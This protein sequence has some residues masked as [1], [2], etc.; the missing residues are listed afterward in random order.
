PKFEFIKA[1]SLGKIKGVDT[2][3]QGL[4]KLVVKYP[5]AEV[6]PLANDVLAAIKKQRT[7][8][9]SQQANENKTPVDTFVVSLENEHFLL[10]I[11]PNNPKISDAYK[12]NLIEFNEV[13][14]SDKKFDLK[15]NLLGTDK[16]MIVLK[17]FANGKAAME[18]YEN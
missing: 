13:F 17:S 14:Y 5:N 15:S 18:Y 12:S 10:T 6:T 1:M 2:L 16:Q 4:K 11:L 8:E 9:P 3:E 7:P